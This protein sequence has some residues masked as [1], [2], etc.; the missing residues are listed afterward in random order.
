MPLHDTII[1]GPASL[2]IQS[3]L[4]NNAQAHIDSALESIARAA[5]LAVAAG[6]LSS[7]EVALGDCSPEP[8]F[9][10][11]QIE[12]RAAKFLPQGVAR[13]QY[14]F[15]NANLGSAAGQNRLL[16][17]L[18]T[19]LVLILNPDTLVAPN[20]FVELVRPMHKPDVGIVEARQ[21][22]IE[23]AKDYDAVT[24]ETSW[25]T[26]ACALVSAA[27]AKEVNGFDP[28]SFFLYCDDVDFSWRVR[29]AGYKVVFQ[30]S[31]AL[32]HDKRLST[33]GKWIVGGAEEYY[34]AEAAMI[35]AHKFSNGALA[36]RIERQL[37]AAGSELEQKAAK[38]YRELKTAGQLPAQIDRDHRVAQ[39]V[40]GYYAKHRF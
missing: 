12:E 20:I 13:I 17:D 33:A 39:F 5:D 19:E 21:V 10:P 11:E 7:V 16:E 23:H 9:T 32:F 38:K 27:V 24:G 2:R 31:A 34:S 40:G 35:L 4:Y 3:V 25:A 28:E 8:V 29:L 36:D 30:P 14:T 1:T 22:P 6:V 18:Q 15:F 37:L 26:T